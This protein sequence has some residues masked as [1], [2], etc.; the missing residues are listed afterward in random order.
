M[1]WRPVDVV[2]A[3]VALAV[4]ASM[5]MSAFSISILKSELT[6][7]RSELLK[8][9]VGGAISIISMYIGAEVQR[10]KDKD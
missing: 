10:R 2:V 6:E 8:V 3:L 4:S 5:L 9:A 7:I 1:N